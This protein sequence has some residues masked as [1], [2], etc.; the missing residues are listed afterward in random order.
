MDKAKLMYLMHHEG[1][2]AGPLFI[3]NQLAKGSGGEAG[4]RRKFEIQLGAK[5]ASKAKEKIE[6]AD[7]DVEKAYRA[8]LAVFA[9]RQFAQSA[10]YFCGAAIVPNRLSDILLKIGGE[11][12]SIVE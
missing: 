9:D 3:K 5:G 7:D 11:E 12:I 2:G 6:E 8:W 4:L 1:E 10:K